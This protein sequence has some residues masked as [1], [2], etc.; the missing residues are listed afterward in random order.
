MAGTRNGHN[1]YARRYNAV[2]VTG[3]KDYKKGLKWLPVSRT[4]FS[5]AYRELS[6]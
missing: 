4:P 6:Q 1:G 2:T 5:C 3:N